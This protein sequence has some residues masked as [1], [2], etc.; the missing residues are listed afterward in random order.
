MLV[1]KK[2]VRSR[3]AI[4]HAFLLLLQLLVGLAWGLVDAEQLH[5]EV[6]GGLLGDDAGDAV[7]AVPEVRGHGQRA[8]LPLA[9]AGDAALVALDDLRDGERNEIR[10]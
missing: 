3:A 10:I 2:T 7:V 4:F 9:H 1:R 5:G 8:D 6:E